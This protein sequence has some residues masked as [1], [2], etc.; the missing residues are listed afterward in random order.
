MPNSVVA[1]LVHPVLHGIRIPKQLEGEPR[2]RPLSHLLCDF[3]LLWA[4]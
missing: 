4:P 2:T 1:V 3:L